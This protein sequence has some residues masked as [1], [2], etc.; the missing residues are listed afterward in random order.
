MADGDPLG[1][2]SGSDPLVPPGAL[3]RYLEEIRRHPLLTRED[4]L[5]VARL[6]RDGDD[7]AMDRLVRSNLRLVA[8]VARRYSRGSRSLEELINEGNVGLLRAARRFDPDRGVRFATYAIWWIRQAVLAALAREARIVRV[9]AS[10]V[11]TARR[12]KRAAREIH[13]RDGRA[14]R[15]DEIAGDLGLSVATVREA[16]SWGAHDVSLDAPLAVGAGSLLEMLPD[17]DVA[18][19]ASH[20]ER[21]AVTGF[22]SEHVRRLPEGESF[23]IRAFYGLD[24]EEPRS[25]A[26]IG[27]DLG[28]SRD[29]A[30]S[31]RDRALARMRLA[32]RVRDESSS[33]CGTPPW[34]APGSAPSVL[35]TP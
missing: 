28:I 32:G 8:A 20:V 9:P 26:A 15:A 33:T 4:E 25:L 35:D 24:G 18:D 31:L 6:A 13:R 16:A 10:R 17:P 19:P 30:G 3:A 34:E 27:S 23:V 12:V 2:T 14:G 22:V 21:E 29:R 5:A 7:E 11:A 1:P